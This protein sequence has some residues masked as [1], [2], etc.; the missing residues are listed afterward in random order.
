MAESSPVL[1][2]LSG[3]YYPVYAIVLDLS[4]YFR[5]LVKFVRVLVDLLCF[6]FPSIKSNYICKKDIF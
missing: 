1:H 4:S 5:V 6:P 3:K 2:T